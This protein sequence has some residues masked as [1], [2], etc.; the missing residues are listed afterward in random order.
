M[1]FKVFISIFIVS[2]SVNPEYLYSGPVFVDQNLKKKI[3][4]DKFLKWFIQKFFLFLLTF[5]KEFQLQEE[6]VDM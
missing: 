5:T 2:I 3:A 1:L 4:V 6:P